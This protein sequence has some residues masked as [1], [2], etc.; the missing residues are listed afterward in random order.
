MKEGAIPT[1]NPPVQSRTSMESVLERG[2][3][4]ITKREFHNSELS[5]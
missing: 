3:S 2:T 1:K 4:S 5:S